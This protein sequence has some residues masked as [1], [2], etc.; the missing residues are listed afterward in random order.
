VVVAP[1]ASEL[2]HAIT[3]AVTQRLSADD[4]AAAFT[5]YPSISGSIAEVAR[6]PRE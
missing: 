5:V 4:L 1:R 3:L 6:L 2:V